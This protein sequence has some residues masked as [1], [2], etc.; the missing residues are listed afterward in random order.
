[1]R[2]R[3]VARTL[4]LRQLQQI[5]FER[6]SQRAN[7]PMQIE[8]PVFGVK[9]MTSRD[10][11]TTPSVRKVEPTCVSLSVNVTLIEDVVARSVSPHLAAARSVAQQDYLDVTT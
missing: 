3:L 10:L 2:V 6:K 5:G 8:L 11:A 7:P 9:L 4:R 1:M